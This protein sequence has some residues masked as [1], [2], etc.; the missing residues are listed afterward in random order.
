MKI[1]QDE[2]LSWAE[3][4]YLS[5]GQQRFSMKILSRLT[6]YSQARLSMQKG[7]G[8]IESVVVIAFSRGLG[9]DPVKQLLT[10][11]YFG[12]LLRTE[13]PSQEEVL[14][15]VSTKD[16]AREL[17]FRLGA[18]SRGDQPLSA[19]DENLGFLRWYDAAVKRGE[20]VNIAAAMTI[21]A[22]VLSS[23]NI[24]NS[25]SM[26]ELHDMCEAGD[27]NYRVSLVAAGHI[28][29]EEAGYESDLRERTLEN[30]ADELFFTYF[31]QSLGH[32]ERQARAVAD[33]RRMSEHLG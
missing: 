27:L 15:L 5:T 11:P 14:A 7:R 13:T 12:R 3:S 6:G 22:P 26:G 23:R 20:G 18:P 17:H 29:L 30:V 32:M 28:T 19:A 8:Y 31:K 2:F 10:F 25:W 9:L 4:A 21:S 33:L 1:P 16:L 24:R